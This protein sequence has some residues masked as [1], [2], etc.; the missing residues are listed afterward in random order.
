MPKKDPNTTDL[1]E[2]LPLE[3]KELLYQSLA[4]FLSDNKR[5]LFDRLAPM[6]TRHI[7]LLL[8]DIYQPH[9]AS[10]VMRSCD[11]FGIQDL[12]VVATRNAYNPNDQVSMGSSKWVDYFSHPDILTA[13]NYLREKG[14]KIV[15]TTPHT[16]DTTISELDLSQP[17][18]LVFGTELTGLTQEAISNA[19]AYVK[20][21]MFGFTES[22]NISVSA[23]ISLYDTTTRLRS[24][25]EI[26]WRLQESDI[27]DIKLHWCLSAINDGQAIM[28][29]LCERL[30]L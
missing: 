14:Y 7:T 23:A 9:N 3:K 26:P 20:I 22:F 2:S 19:D 1:M 28:R 29:Q 13:Y 4:E 8:E 6:R 21:P 25:E 15:A 24:N 5:Q 17:V 11:C 12:H 16:N 18:A 10:A 30:E 27:L